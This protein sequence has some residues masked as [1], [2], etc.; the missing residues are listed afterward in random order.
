MSTCKHALGDGT[1]RV[2]AITELTLERAGS[3]LFKT[4]LPEF[5]AFR[6]IRVICLAGNVIDSSPAIN[7]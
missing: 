7:Q 4:S 3:I 1:V 5:I 6:P 2:K